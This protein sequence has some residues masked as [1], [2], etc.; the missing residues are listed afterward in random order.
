MI[1]LLT[2]VSV[3]FASPFFGL[4]AHGPGQQHADADS[5]QHGRDRI[6][7]YYI[8]QIVGHAAKPFLL[9]V[10]AAVIKRPG[11]SRRCRAE[12]SFMRALVANAAGE[13]LYAATD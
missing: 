13:V 1:R 8:G 10:T 11:H 4:P 7:A 12:G 5:H 6:S 9:E 3:Y 2:R